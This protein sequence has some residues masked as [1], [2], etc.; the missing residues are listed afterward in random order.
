M[1][2]STKSVQ[3]RVPGRMTAVLDVFFPRLR[4]VYGYRARASFYGAVFATYFPSAPKR[5]FAPDLKSEAFSIEI[6]PHIYD[7]I[8]NG[9]DVAFYVFAFNAFEAFLENKSL[10]AATYAHFRVELGD[11]TPDIADIATQAFRTQLMDASA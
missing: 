7:I 3:I 1:G 8:R 5:L 4:E 10:R 11:E 2:I 6:D 9:I